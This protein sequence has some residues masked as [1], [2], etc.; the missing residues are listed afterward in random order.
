M[1]SVRQGFTVDIHNEEDEKEG[2]QE[3]VTVW[4]GSNGHGLPALSIQEL[5]ILRD[6]LSEYIEHNKNLGNEREVAFLELVEGFYEATENFK[7]NFNELQEKERKSIAYAKANDGGDFLIFLKLQLAY[8]IGW[9]ECKEFMNES[10]DR[11]ENG[12]NN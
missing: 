8:R 12:N 6:K 3:K 7:K 1:E 11:N 2:F 10:Q 9:D 4:I 5:T